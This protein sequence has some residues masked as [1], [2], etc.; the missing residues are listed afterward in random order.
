MTC[1]L[2]ITGIT[3]MIVAVCIFFW[4]SVCSHCKQFG[5]CDSLWI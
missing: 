4:L 2:V 5:V 3:V 1:S